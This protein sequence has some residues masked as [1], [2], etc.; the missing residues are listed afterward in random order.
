MNEDP[1][2]PPTIHPLSDVQTDQIGTG[3]RIWQYA[4]I[5][6]GAVIGANCN[7]NAHTFIE[8]EVRIGD[9]V[10]LKCGVYLWDGTT[11]GNDVFVGPNVTF[12]NDKYP[13]SKRYPPRF[14][15]VVIKEGASLGANATILGGVTV[16]K[17]A[18][19]GAGSVVTKDV[20]DSELWVGI[21]AKFV[22]K[23]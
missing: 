10:T 23:I 21:P 2:L 14:Q 6:P 19:I 18:M 16:G 11:L 1:T 22:R 9:N 3:T 8:N 4:V 20:P 17:T 13:K 7:I 15:T 12:T 5:L